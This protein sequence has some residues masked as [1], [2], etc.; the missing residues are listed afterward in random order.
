M[1]SENKNNLFE[2][3]NN[4]LYLQDANKEE[5]S[6]S[7]VTGTVLTFNPCLKRPDVPE[8]DTPIKAVSFFRKTVPYVGFLSSPLVILLAVTNK[9]IPFT[10]VLVLIFLF[11]FIAFVTEWYNR[12][13]VLETNAR[14][15]KEFRLAN[16]QFMKECKDWAEFP[17]QLRF[18]RG[19]MINNAISFKNLEDALS[20]QKAVVENYLKK[21]QPKND[22]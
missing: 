1:D 5:I 10:I 12:F 20:L 17:Y 19:N 16:E 21:G 4:I 15:L 13:M 8:L 2:I 7:T 3:K 9:I 11:I 6:L 14:L 18:Q 22:N